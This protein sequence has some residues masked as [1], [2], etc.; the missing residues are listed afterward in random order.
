MST[1]A[2]LAN[3]A[4]DKNIASITPTSQ[5]G[6]RRIL[7]TLDF[8]TARVVVEY[9]PGLGVITRE[10]LKR[11]MPNTKLIVIETNPVFAR[12]LSG[13]IDDERLSVINDSAENVLQILKDH[14]E[15][16]A[17]CI[18]SGIPFSLFPLALKD[19]ILLNTKEALGEK[20]RFYVYQFLVAS[21][22]KDDIQHKLAEHMTIVRKEME[23]LNIPPLRIYEAANSSI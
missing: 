9:G 19:R 11:M 18:I 21:R 10:L 14:Q 4:R 6:I 23:I 5:F 8:S 12:S 16:T 17:D 1:L 7:K 3:L 22:K 13:R 15:Q 2:Y 20:G